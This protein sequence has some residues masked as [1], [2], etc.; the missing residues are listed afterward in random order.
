MAPAAHAPPTYTANWMT[1]VQ[2]TASMP[3]SSVYSSVISAIKPIETARSAVPGSSAGASREPSLPPSGVSE[4]AAASTRPVANSR[5]PS[6]SE[7]V[8]RNRPAVER[9]AAGPNLS[10]TSS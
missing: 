2:M 5:N 8:A 6:E 9:P 10:V 1:S 7:R 3:P 4:S